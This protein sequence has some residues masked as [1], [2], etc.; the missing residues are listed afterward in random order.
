M[1]WEVIQKKIKMEIIIL[2]LALYIY[3]MDTFIVQNEIRIFI[4][5]LF[6]KLKN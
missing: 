4:T 2:F 6:F 3:H 1:E 5:Y